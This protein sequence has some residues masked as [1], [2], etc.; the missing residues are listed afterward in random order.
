MDFFN[1]FGII[2]IVGLILF[3]GCIQTLAGNDKPKPE[4]CEKVFSQEA[5]STCY[6]EIALNTQDQ[7]Y[8]EKITTLRIKDQCYID[9]AQGR[10]WTTLNNID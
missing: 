5:K 1:V 4:L 8:C 10:T 2:T 3:A 7:D 6:H 9:L